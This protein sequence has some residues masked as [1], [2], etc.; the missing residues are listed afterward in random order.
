[1]RRKQ[2]VWSVGGLAREKWRKKM[3]DDFLVPWGTAIF[4]TIKFMRFLVPL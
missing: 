3:T 4:P 1:M 2:E